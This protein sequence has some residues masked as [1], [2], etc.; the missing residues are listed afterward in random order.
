MKH[1]R[2]L[3]FVLGALACL[4]AS[5]FW[6]ARSAHEPPLVPPV[7]A[8]GARPAPAREPA[9][10]LPGSAA[11][12]EGEPLADRRREAREPGLLLARL[13]DLETRRP[14]PG[15]VLHARHAADVVRADE[16]GELRIRLGAPRIEF[17]AGA[18]GYC[19]LRG[20]LAAETADAAR[21]LEIPLVASS[22][23]EG[24]VVDEEGDPIR[25]AWVGPAAATD[26]PVVDP[27]PPGIP[28]GW[29]LRPEGLGGAVATDEG[30]AFRLLGLVP[31]S[32]GYRLHVVRTGYVSKDVELVARAA[33]VRTY[34]PIV[35][36]R[37]PGSPS[38][39]VEGH[40]YLN[41]ELVAAEVWFVCE[42]EYREASAERGSYRFPALVPGSGLLVACP[43][44]WFVGG[45]A[46][47]A[48]PWIP[49]SAVELDVADGA[50]ILQDIRMSIPVDAI[51]G[52][53]RHADGSPWEHGV[54][55][56]SALVEIWV[57]TDAD[58]RFEVRVPV[59][60][61]DY[62]IQAG[63]EIG[64]PV[65][66]VVAPGTS[67]VDL[68]EA[69]LP[70]VRVQALDAVSGVELTRIRIQ[71]RRTGE[72]GAWYP[73][74]DA[75]FRAPPGPLDIRVSCRQYEET[76]LQVRIDLDR[77]NTFL[78]ELKPRR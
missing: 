15:A 17:E 55:A 23:V 60:G 7:P 71:V 68:V 45:S 13:V 77:E 63:S 16:R 27:V 59:T 41:G 69:D 40:T 51:A 3:A 65:S 43:D 36:E 46:Y 66:D 53:V 18:E 74:G 42:E 61:H 10:S 62:R 75:S 21:P 19:V 73:A 64:S 9:V 76:V 47:R 49:G 28:A 2:T 58:G 6:L 4:A 31:G 20:V 1:A 56:V 30:G 44:D 32:T 11:A 37:V 52:R 25:G 14:I 34:V 67:G 72:E 22:P 35:L 8:E 29:K 57:P 70:L 50:E 54:Q 26:A 39:R 38:A 12:Q 5:L 48:N 33:G 78:A 24:R